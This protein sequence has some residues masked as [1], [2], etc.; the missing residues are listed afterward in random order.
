MGLY[1]VSDGT[2]RPY[3]LR[4][5]TPSFAHLQCYPQLVAGLDLDEAAL[6]LGSLNI[7]AAEV[8]R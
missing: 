1:L 6:V 4:F 7:A 5:R 3:R 2:A 8:D